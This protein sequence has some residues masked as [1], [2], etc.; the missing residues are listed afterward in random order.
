VE[1][2]SP[3]DLG[4]EQRELFRRWP[5]GVSVVVAESGG[6]RAGLT[7]SS[8]VSLS[9]EPPL[10]AISLAHVASLFEV[11]QEAGEWTASVLSGEQ[12][13]LA[14]HFARSVPPLVLW[15]GIPVRDDD[16]R[17]IR[18]AVGWLRVRTIDELRTG[19]HTLFIGEVLDVERGAATTSLV[20]RNRTY[21]SL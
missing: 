17:L 14:Q 20:Y 15:D 5:A 8:L 3:R 6:R 7:V 21:T 4:L 10:V 13:W 1:E 2:L 19:D 11:L 12:D 18:D 16:P 9:L